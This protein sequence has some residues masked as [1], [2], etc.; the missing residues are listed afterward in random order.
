MA[1]VLLYATNLNET[2]RLAQARQLA[3]YLPNGDIP[4]A[5]VFAQIQQNYPSER[6]LLIADQFEELYTLCPD[7]TI[8]RNF[9]DKLTTDFRRGEAFGEGAL[10]KIDKL[11][12]ECFA[13]TS[14][15]VLV[16]TMRADFLGN[17]LS[18]RPF[19]DVLQKNTDLKLGPMNREELTGVMLTGAFGIALII[20]DH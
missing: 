4:L 15:T 14:A 2:E 11:L 19:A 18:Y 1:L 13:P 5:D 10:D 17:A 9:L 3:N 20:F 7:E 8:R 12:P 16:L 6:V